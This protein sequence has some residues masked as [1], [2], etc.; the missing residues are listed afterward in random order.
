MTRYTKLDKR[1]PQYVKES[2]RSEASSSRSSSPEVP[3]VKE[4]KESASPEVDIEK[5]LSNDKG[6]KPS[7]RI[8][9]ESKKKPKS[10]LSEP[11]RL[12]KRA[13]LLRLKSKKAKD[14]AKK[15]EFN[16]QIQEIERRVTVLNGE[17]GLKG[18]KRKYDDTLS[19]SAAVANGVNPWKAMEA[20]RRKV[21]EV[22]STIRRDKREQERMSSQRCFACRE[23]GHSA[24]T[25]PTMSA[26]DHQSN[27][28]DQ[29]ISKNNN[30]NGGIVCCYRCGSTEHSLAKCRKP[31]PQVGMDLPFAS[32][33]ICGEKGHLAS[34]C[35]QNQGR[36]IY[37]NGGC[38]KLCQSVDHLAKDCT[39]RTNSQGI[40]TIS[41]AAIS[42]G[43]A[44]PN[45][46]AGA[47]EDDFHSLS[48]KRREIEQQ[49]KMTGNVKKRK[50][51]QKVVSF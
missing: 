36:G 15:N 22:R 16:R 21:T 40:N 5:P 39:L 14:L 18:T 31:E 17:R 9:V 49:E 51:F 45:M 19:P 32:C 23:M 10:E 47:D 46:Q 28:V 30:N 50:S 41:N 7:T 25:C 37:P 34:K 48:R 38:C 29:V 1:K 33:F 44:D 2:A 26:A 3:I 8:V 35:S 20:E 4:E 43:G 6:K 42:L 12:L 27:K 24:K 13:K 11:S